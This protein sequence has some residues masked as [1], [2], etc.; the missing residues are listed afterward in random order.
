[1]F[2]R[3][4][5]DELPTKRGNRG[6]P[7]YRS[8]KSTVHSDSGKLFRWRSFWLRYSPLEKQKLESKETIRKGESRDLHE[9]KYRV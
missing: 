1:M 7:L 3:F 4:D 2:S 9:H 6:S 5:Y 8:S